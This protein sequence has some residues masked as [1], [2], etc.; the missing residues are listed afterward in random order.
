[1]NAGQK[2]FSE[3]VQIYKDSIDLT[4][5]LF[6]L[7]VGTSIYKDPKLNLKFSD[8]DAV[9]LQEGFR[10][11]SEKM[12]DENRINLQILT[13]GTSA[14]EKSSSKKNILEA[15]DNISKNALPHDIIIIFLSGHGMTIDDDFFYLTSDAGTVD[16]H[17]DATSRNK[18]CLSS[19]ELLEK[20]KKIRSNK[21]VIVLDACHS[22]Q[23]TQILSGSTKALSTTQEKA[24]E[25]LEDKMGVYILAS[26]ESN[27]KSFETEALE[28]GLLTFGL[29]RGMSGGASKNG[30]INVIDLLNYASNEAEDI[31]K[32]VLN[33]TQRP[34][35]NIAKG[36][37]SFPI[38][39]EN[40]ELKV[41]LPKDKITIG[42]SFIKKVLKDHIFHDPHKINNELKA[43]LRERGAFGAS[44]AFIFSPKDAD[45]NYT[46]NGTY[47]TQDG[48]IIIEWYILKN[49]EIFKGPFT[50]SKKIEKKSKLINI[51]ISTTLREIQQSNS[52]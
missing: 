4:P 22:G 35:L 49:E 12:Y 6:G 7:F 43:L 16:L 25:F 19:N 3:T 45:N 15:L 30:V 32:R 46:I 14:D 20:L 26:S 51:I 41:E 9:A 24:L 40:A 18:V 37:N 2:G 39:F 28:K 10:K 33:R 29:L 17:Q 36:G 50:K 27:Q 23:I 21:Q 11:I 5:G 44:T 42:E 13:S 1:M 31:G 47:D 48:E 52:E 34:V 8:D 38:G